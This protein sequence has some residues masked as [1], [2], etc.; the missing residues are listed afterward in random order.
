MRV[1]NSM[2]AENFRKSIQRTTAS[3]AKYQKQVST[4]LLVGEPSD[5]PAGTNR[6]LSIRTAISKNEQYVSNANNAK[7]LLDASSGVY[8]EVTEIL[9]RAHGLAHNALSDA[10]NKEDLTFFATEVEQLIESVVD[11]G[12]TDFAGTYLFAGNKTAQAPFVASRSGNITKTATAPIRE[13][14]NEDDSI[15]MNIDDVRSIRLES[16][17]GIVIKDNGNEI[18]AVVDNIG[19]PDGASGEVKVYLGGIGE[20]VV[21]SP[22]AKVFNSY[23][24]QE[25]GDILSVDYRGDSGLHSERVSKNVYITTNTPGDAV[26]ERIFDQLTRLKDAFESGATDE[27]DI[28]FRGLEDS[29]T[30]I[31]NLQTEVGVKI[32]RV[33]NIVDRLKDANTS[34]SAF[35]AKIEEVDMTDAMTDFR[36]QENVLNAALAS[37]A[38][39]LQVTLFNYL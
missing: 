12:N 22:N 5:D 9:N 19:T 32:D 8:D 16:N 3:L 39:V 2:I 26:F 6:I 36:M 30:H 25:G 27:I 23:I 10:T 35:S 20:D 38:R 13:F 14:N 33:D 17:K 31:A 34:L 11:S 29:I 21:I 24:E 37:G 18:D 4:G 1:T 28:L 15:L 7:S